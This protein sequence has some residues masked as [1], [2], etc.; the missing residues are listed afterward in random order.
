ML[1]R[2][3]AETAIIDTIATARII[4]A[5]APNSGITQVPIISI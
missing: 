4:A 3:L 5:I 2:V 1:S